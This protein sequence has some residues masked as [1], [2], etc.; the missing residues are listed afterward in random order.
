[1]VVA[2][3]GCG[4]IGSWLALHITIPDVHLV[5][6]DDDRVEQHNLETSAFSEQHV[7]HSKAWAL[8]EMV[9]RLNAIPATPKAVTLARGDEL[10][11]ADLI[12]DCFDNTESRALT[13]GLNTL[14][15]G[16]GED[17]TGSAVWDHR[18]NLPNASI[19][20]G[21]NP[22]C[23]HH[24]GKDILHAM[25]IWGAHLVDTYIAMG[26]KSNIFVNNRLEVIG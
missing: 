15:V 13:C 26:T 19:P 18:Y 4:A 20:R 9:W 1:M 8:A 5:L 16:V 3:C 22:V 21:E 7:G 12:V 24:L 25:A 23:T 10:W 17:L 2:I 14:H 11:S 6:I